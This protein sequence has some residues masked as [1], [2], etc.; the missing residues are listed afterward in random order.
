MF[1]VTA[2]LLTV[3]T[4]VLVPLFSNHFGRSNNMEMRNQ[5]NN[6]AWVWMSIAVFLAMLGLFFGIYCSPK[7]P[8]WEK[9]LKRTLPIVVGVIFVVIM[10]LILACISIE[11]WLIAF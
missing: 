1:T 7:Y 3:L 11:H 4:I 2:V 9:R 8:R 6:S 5:I 10:A